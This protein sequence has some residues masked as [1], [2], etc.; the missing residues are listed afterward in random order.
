MTPPQK[1]SY[2]E[3]ELELLKTQLA[4]NHANIALA[5]VS[6]VELNKMIAERE[7]KLHPTQLELPHA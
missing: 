2:D 6:C 7:A 3:L 4:L 1:P 5:Q